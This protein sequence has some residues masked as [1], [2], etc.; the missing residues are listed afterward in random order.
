[1]AV[2]IVTYGWHN[3]I[4]AK[5]VE[6]DLRPMLMITLKAD[7]RV[8]NMYLDAELIGDAADVASMF[9]VTRK[10]G[11]EYVPV[12]PKESGTMCIGYEEHKYIAGI[13]GAYY[14]KCN[15]RYGETVFFG[16]DEMVKLAGVLECAAAAL[17]KQP[18]DYYAAVRDFRELE[19][20]IAL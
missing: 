8:L 14:L 17:R 4:G 2:H 13:T 10:T 6:R 7:K 1:M 12:H 3:W 18:R 5:I 9:V 11:Y 15:H 19:A 16:N 20:L